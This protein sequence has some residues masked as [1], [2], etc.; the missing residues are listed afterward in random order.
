MLRTSREAESILRSLERIAAARDSIE[1]QA[2]TVSAERSMS[3]DVL[4]DFLP[5]PEQKRWRRLIREIAATARRVQ[6][7][8]QFNQQLVLDA[9]AYRD[10]LLRLLSGQTEDDAY[11]VSRPRDRRAPISAF[12]NQSA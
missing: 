3:T 6:A 2:F 1:A 7:A 8:N 10:L 5:E 12:L 11:P 4:M 9:I